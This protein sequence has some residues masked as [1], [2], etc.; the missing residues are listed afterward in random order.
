MNAIEFKRFQISQKNIKIQ[1]TQISMTVTPVGQI[2]Q[3]SGFSGT[4]VASSVK[5][6]ASSTAILI[7]RG[8]SNG[9]V[10]KITDASFDL[11]KTMGSFATDGTT[12]ADIFNESLDNSIS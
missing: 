11:G 2:Y 3:N 12:D 10:D 5:A 9:I 1:L 4:P 7:K 8:Y 6:I